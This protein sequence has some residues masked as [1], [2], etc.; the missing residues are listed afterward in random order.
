MGNSADAYLVF[1]IKAPEV[2]SYDEVARFPKLRYDE[3]DEEY[4]EAKDVWATHK[5]VSKPTVEYNN[6]TQAIYREYWKAKNDLWNETGLDMLRGGSSV[7][8]DYTTQFLV[9]EDLE[10]RAWDYGHKDVTDFMEKKPTPEQL[11]SLQEVAEVLGVKK[12]DAEPRWWLVA[13]YG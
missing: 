12:E 13:Y 5:G 2:S 7:Y 3:V 9:I 10:A 8:D 6:D 1:G 4:I 11:Q